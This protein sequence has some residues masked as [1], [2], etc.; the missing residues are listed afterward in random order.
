MVRPPTRSP[1]RN[2]NL[3]LARASFH[4]P[5]VMPDGIPVFRG[6]NFDGVR[7]VR[8]KKGF[9]F[10]A[11]ALQSGESELL[12]RWQI[13]SQS[14]SPTKASYLSN[15]VSGC[16][17]KGGQQR[18]SRQLWQADGGSAATQLLEAKDFS[19]QG[20]L[21]VATQFPTKVGKRRKSRL[22]TT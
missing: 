6:L 1:N 14:R 13:Y 19:Y 9:N 7:L 22:I 15:F 2:R 3:K 18:N 5:D 20:L 16:N 12:S 11:T 21:S 8:N 17:P 4:D 10:G